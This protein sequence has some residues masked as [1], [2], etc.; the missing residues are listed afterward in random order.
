MSL[1]L[2]R[3][4]QYRCRKSITMK[5]VFVLLVCAVAVFADDTAT[6]YQVPVFPEDSW[7]GERIVNG[8]PAATN[9]FPHQT[10]VFSTNNNSTGG[11]CGGS[12][13]SPI[14]VFS[15]A[16]CTRGFAWYHIGVGSINRLS[17][18][19]TQVSNFV[20]EH[21]QYNPSNLNNDVCAVRLNTPLQINAAVQVIRLPRRS[22]F[23]QLWVG[24]R[25]YV[26]GFGRTTN[27]GPISNQLMFT[28]IRIISNAECAG[29]YGT[30]VIIASTICG[31]G[32][33]FNSQSTCN[34]D[35]G[36]PLILRQGGASGDLHIGVVSFVSGAGCDSGHPSGYARSTH[37]TEW[38]YANTGIPIV[39]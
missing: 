18:Q 29:V 23:T 8:Q 1:A 11:F 6:P 30:N 9:Q 17:Q 19:Q 10:T 33:D 32:W 24:D 2:L 20:I 7:I 4:V 5:A 35:S 28:N 15:A 27:T 38:V 16:H 25:A 34:G 13:V 36:G 39:A 37:F 12:L 31:R 22:E 14:W 3:I 26:S 21:A